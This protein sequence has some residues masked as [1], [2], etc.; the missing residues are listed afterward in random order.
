MAALALLEIDNLQIN[1]RGREVPGLDGSAREFVER[2]EKTGIREQ[3]AAKNYLVLKEPLWIEDE[4]SSLIAL[5]YP[6]Y[7]ISYTLQY[8]DS[9]VNS[10][11]LEI[12]FNETFDPK[13]IAPART[14]CLE[15]EIEPLKRLGLGKGA[16]YDNTLVISR[17]GVQRNTLRF[18]DEFVRH[19]IL[20]LL[21][22]VYLAG[23][24]KAH[25]IAVKSGHHLNIKLLAKLKAYKDRAGAAGVASTKG[26]VASGETLEAEDIMK[27]LP[28]RYPF[29][30]VDK[31]IHIE[32][33]KR[34]IGIKNV[35][36]NDYFFQGHFPGKPVMPGVLL[37][38]AMA[39]VGGVLMLA[40][41]EHRGEIAYFLAA[42]QIKFRKT[43]Q[44]GD[45]LVIEVEV[46]RV[47]SRTGQV[48][49]VVRVD[50][51]VVAEAVLRFMLGKR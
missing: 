35:T 36:I 50:D 7:K 29:L 3:S 6:G 46:D 34:A 18:K 38:E 28:H 32:Y 19:K 45:Q 4:Q 25:L 41:E 14:F 30:L 11:F 37:V 33:G 26:F 43:V 51:K 49:G 20:D 16:N 8:T 48:R 10:E 2:I 21:G 27:I 22:D 44:P 15:E 13:E 47:K 17:Q 12:N 23:P 5:P 39:Q 9:F 1:I 40:S 24:I 31:I 42:D